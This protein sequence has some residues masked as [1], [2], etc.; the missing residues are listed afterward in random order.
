[1]L[2]NASFLGMMLYW[3]H[4]YAKINMHK[5]SS[6]NRVATQLAC[7]TEPYP[8]TRDTQTPPAF[9]YPSLNHISLHL[10]RGH[11]CG[12]QIAFSYVSPV[13]RQ[14][15][16]GLHVRAHVANGKIRKRRQKKKRKQE[17]SPRKSLAKLLASVDYRATI[18]L[19]AKDAKLD[20]IS[21]I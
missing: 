19:C 9:N 6:H 20:N 1:M 15:P 8:P 2:N 7:D 5:F 3:T 18:L 13:W 11:I 4:H 16:G 21:S 10:H 12:T 17:N 14:R